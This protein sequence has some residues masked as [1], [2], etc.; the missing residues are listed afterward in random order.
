MIPQDVKM[1]A[2]RLFQNTWKIKGFRVSDTM[3]I[4]EV[5]AYSE[6]GGIV[7]STIVENSTDVLD[8]LIKGNVPESL[9]SALRQE[10]KNIEIRRVVDILQ[11]SPKAAK[12]AIQKMLGK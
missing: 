3:R 6:L 2:H 10:T 4:L 5:L 9:S 11:N 12:V 1:S 7:K 8:N